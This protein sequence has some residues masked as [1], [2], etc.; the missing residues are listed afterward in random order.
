MMF[1]FYTYMIYLCLGN[2]YISQSDHFLM[3]FQSKN[4][5]R[6]PSSIP[7]ISGFL[8]LSYWRSQ[9]IFLFNIEK[10]SIAILSEQ[11]N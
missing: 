10:V 3:P 7:N 1:G 6:Q 8:N 11:T 4:G 2:R 9:N 5:R